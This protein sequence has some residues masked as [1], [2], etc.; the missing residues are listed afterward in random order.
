MDIL[1]L[2]VALDS[3]TNQFGPYDP[4]TVA[5]VNELAV[6][7][8]RAGDSDQA[9]GLLSQALDGLEQ[10]PGGEG[11]V[12][13]NLLCTLGEIMVEQCR[14][15][16]ARTVYREV[17]D[18]C[19]RRSGECHPSS[20]AAKGDLALVLFSLGEVTE[21]GHVE[22]QAIAD[23]RIHLGCKHPV[24]CVLAWNRVL[25]YDLSGDSNAAQEIVRN[26]LAWLLTEQDSRLEPDQQTIRYM[27]A[28][29]LNWDTATV[30]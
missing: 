20:L 2:F 19:V 9:V 23:A 15:E 14:M 6:A 27:L 16:Q 11:T 3:H 10:P 7:L 29:R 18:L 25:R 17:V 22:E 21:A 13:V 24:T 5:V 26:E 4:H 12:R 30:C 1:E 28:K 8:W